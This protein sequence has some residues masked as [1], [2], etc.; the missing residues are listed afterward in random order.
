MLLVN[1][2]NNKGLTL[3]E[4]IVSIALVSVVMIFLYRLLANVQY[5]RDE[6]FFASKN[7][8]QKIEITNYMQGRLRFDNDTVYIRAVDDTDNNLTFTLS[9]G[10]QYQMTVKDDKKTLEIKNTDASYG[11]VLRTWTI[12]Q[13]TLGK[14]SCEGH[15][16]ALDSGAYAP[17]ECTIPIYTLNNSNVESN[18][19]TLDDIVITVL[20]RG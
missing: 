6:E 10:V 9:S 3:I 19:N 1:K 14:P 11:G 4:L 5:D 2:L 8:E 17:V 15:D 18:N 7:Q 20:R 13:G 16:I 12:E